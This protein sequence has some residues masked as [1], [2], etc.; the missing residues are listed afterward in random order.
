MIQNN[1]NFLS[2]SIRSKWL[3]VITLLLAIV[4]LFFTFR[5]VDWTA[6]WNTIQNGHYEYLF[7]T[8][9]ITCL[10]YLFRAIRWSLLVRS[11]RKIQFTSIFWA[12]MVGYMGNAFLPARMGELMRSAFL[13]RQ[14][15][16]GTSFVLATALVERSLDAIALVLIGASSLLIQPNISPL[17]KNSLIFMAF[18]GSIALLVIFAAPFQ[19]NLFHRVVAK[20]PINKKFSLT[21]S[22]QINRFLLGIHSLHNVRRLGLFTLLTG[23]I[24]LVDAFTNTIGVR[25]LS[26]SL[27]ID[28]AFILLA[29]LG[30]SSAI[31]ST[32]GYIGVYQ[33]VAVIVLM[34]FGFSRANALA[35]ILISQVVNYLLVG[36]W[37]LLG[38]WR[39]NKIR[40][41]HL[42]TSSTL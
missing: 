26:Q 17:L 3:L 14:N 33:F 11:D 6:F 18:S 9:P 34:P 31:P 27:S 22:P 42:T 2:Q 32:P 41:D 13:G 37:G 10:N 30:L 19:E 1:N 35:Y 8:I 5:G 15:G 20:L 16:L 23:I 36:F 29:A 25:I 21:I 24:W 7:L 40:S 39:L 38:L 4:L 28:Q 12:N